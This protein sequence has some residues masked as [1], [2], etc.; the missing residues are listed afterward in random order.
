MLLR[1]TCANTCKYL[2]L[3]LACPR[4]PMRGSLFCVSPYNG[5]SWIFRP[6]HTILA[7][8]LGACSLPISASHCTFL[9]TWPHLLSLESNEKLFCLWIS[10]LN[11]VFRYRHYRHPLF[12]YRHSSSA[13]IFSRLLPQDLLSLS[14]T[15]KQLREILMSKAYQ[16]IWKAARLNVRNDPR[17]KAGIDFPPL[18]IDL[19]EPVYASLIFDNHCMVYIHTPTPPSPAK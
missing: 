17:F 2:C 5:Q 16:Q 15:S 8:A 12:L 3:A 10:L 18:P 7:E 11:W 13:K 6:S 9:K 19:S 1:I 4:S 14:R